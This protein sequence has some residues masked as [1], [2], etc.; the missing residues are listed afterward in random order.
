VCEARIS[1][2]G[3][4]ALSQ[5]Q[6]VAL[7][8]I[9]R[10]PDTTLTGVVIRFGDVALLAGEDVEGHLQKNRST[11]SKSKTGLSHPR[12]SSISH[13]ISMRGVAVMGS[14]VSSEKKATAAYFP[15]PFPRLKTSG[16]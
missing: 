8:K 3:G 16:A 15:E 14:L 11:A 1:L 10:N 5:G 13:S 6:V 9:A 4:L 12:C 2:R 7:I